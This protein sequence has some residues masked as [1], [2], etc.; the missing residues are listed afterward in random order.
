MSDVLF[1]QRED[2]IRYTL[3]GGNVD[4]DKIIPHIKVAQD[5]HILPILGTKLYEKLQSDISGSTL[6]GHYSTLL[7]DFVQPCLIHLAAAEFYQ[8]HAYEVSNA[9]VFRHQSENATTRAPSGRSPASPRI[10]GS[11][12]CSPGSCGSTRTAT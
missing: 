12:A 7:T 9:G 2:L 11:S 1:I 3:I 10:T 5:I 8:F 4:T 6:A